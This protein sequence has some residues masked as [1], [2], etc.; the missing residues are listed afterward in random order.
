MATVSKDSFG[1]KSS[2]KVGAKTY[3]IFRLDALEKRYPQGARPPGSL[4]VLLESLL[5]NED[6]LSVRKADVENVAN[7]KHDATPSDEIAFY[8]ARV[9][10]Q[11]FT[12]VPCVVDLAAMRD[13]FQAMGGDPKKIN[14]L[15]PADLVVDHSVQVDSFGTSMAFGINA[16]DRKSTRLNSSHLV[17]SYA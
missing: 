16:R 17:I 2:L 15:R 7:W 6:D 5:R 1:A 11:D 8:V 10:L 3:E 9:L 12:G 14:P 4:K 13:A